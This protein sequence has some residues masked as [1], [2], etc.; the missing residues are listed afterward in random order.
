MNKKILALLLIAMT[1][2]LGACG[3]TVNKN[4]DIEVTDVTFPITDKQI[5][6]VYWQPMNSRMPAVLKNIGEMA[7]FQELQKRTGITLKFESPA[8]GQDAEQF[9]LLVAS[10]NL[11]DVI[12]YKWIGQSQTPGKFIEDNIII[13]LTPFMGKTVVDLPRV[14]EGHDRTKKEIT[15]DKGEYY[16][17]P[18]LRLDDT[19]RMT[20][21]FYIRH[22]WLAALNLPVPD[23]AES[24]YNV[25]V[26]FRDGDPNKNGQKDEIPLISK[27]GEALD[28]L[29]AMFAVNKDFLLVDGKV[30]Y[31]PT[32]E[33]FKEALTYFNK[34]FTEKLLD[35]DYPL[36]DDKA[37]DAKIASEKAGMSYGLSSTVLKHMQTMPSKNSAFD[38][39]L[40][41]QPKAA[42]GIRH[43]NYR[44]LINPNNGYGAAITRDNKYPVETSKMLDYGY[45]DEGQVLFNF[46]IEGES[47]N[48]LPNGE[49]Q[50]TEK[51]RNPTSNLLP[52]EELLRYAFGTYDTA[53][54]TR[55]AY[56]DPAE[57]TEIQKKITNKIWIHEIDPGYLLPTMSYTSEENK[58][59]LAKKGDVTTY[60]DEMI[61]RFIS[62]TV[63]LSEFDNFVAK[64]K[65]MGIDEL[66][67]VEADAYDRFNGKAITE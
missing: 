17:F 23:D 1:V 66:I 39:G 24:L 36:T 37:I 16:M 6:L 2:I 27:K 31:G 41:S 8:L 57:L 5:E 59:M 34:L 62:G 14:L 11:P 29:M 48:K 22:D 15:T 7:C 44:I 45:T 21:G 54:V 19:E 65:E 56:S 13:P 46:G 67:K 43:T 10:K 28:A 55:K 51:I 3:P 9:N 40:M 20:R 32:T 60:R 49:Y 38:L 64:L 47:Y 4:G 12:Y 63:P 42:D 25:L 30:T 50:L 61:D 33:N 53:S 58:L 35:V 26:A 52:A 18:L